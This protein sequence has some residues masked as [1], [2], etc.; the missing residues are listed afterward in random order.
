MRRFRFTRS[1]RRTLPLAGVVLAVLAVAGLWGGHAQAQSR[2]E[3]LIIARNIDDM[4]TNDPSR[5]YEW[6]SQ[7]LDQAAYDTLVTVEPPDVSKIQPKLATKWELSPDGMTYTFHLRPGV[8]F[9]SGNSLTAHDVKFSFMRLKNLKDNPAF[10]MDDVKDVVVVNDT[11]VKIVLSAPNASFLAALAAVPTGAIDSK[12]VMA[13][14]GTDAENAK[15]VDKATE[16]LN[17]NSAG[18]GP[19]VLKGWTKSV[20]AI[21]ERNPHYWGPRPKFARIVFRQVKSGSTQREMLERGDVDV[22]MDFDPDLAAAVKGNPKIKVVEG[23]TMN[24]VYLGV[25]ASKEN[26]KELADKRVR[27]A[28]SY[29]VDYDGIIN[30]LL[31]GAGERPPGM[32]PLG[33]LGVDK[34]MARKQDVNKAKALLREAGYPNGF[35]TKLTFY[36]GLLGAP[37]DAVAAKVQSDLAAVGIRA[38]LDPKERTVAFSEYRGGKSVMILSGWSPDYLDPDPYADAFYKT[39]G[40]VPK[41]VHWENARATDLTLTARKEQDPAKRA[42]LYREIQLI[43]LDEVPHVMLIQP[44]NYVGVSPSIKG[45]VIHPI[46]FVSLQHLSR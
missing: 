28:I 18:S 34:A 29:A 33:L 37:A 24:Q 16:W 38:T 23:L 32:I 46:W 39:G 30:G 27:Q 1:P 42:A 2:E 14:A 13:H 20:E 3:T 31:R 44:K 17:Q 9:A 12:T 35:T 6:T 8:K 36:Q 41:R 11:T 45:Y 4:V 25:T 10:F 40:I 22:A 43:G 21:M 15:D 5:T 26:S 7:I 19:Y